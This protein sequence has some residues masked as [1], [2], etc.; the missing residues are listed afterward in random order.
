MIENLI[1]VGKMADLNKYKESLNKFLDLVYLIQKDISGVRLRSTLVLQRREFSEQIDQVI[2]SLNRDVELVEKGMKNLKRWLLLRKNAL[3]AI[4]NLYLSIDKTI[5]DSRN[6]KEVKDRIRMFGKSAQQ[7][8]V[9]SLLYLEDLWNKDVEGTMNSMQKVA[10]IM[11][12]THEKIERYKQEY[13]LDAD[14]LTSHI[15]SMFNYLLDEEF[16]KFEKLNQ[17]IRDSILPDI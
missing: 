6:E 13:N 3:K 12:V 1:R 17:K 2:E 4:E 14:E 7:E 16:E 5:N 10:S 15:D 11:K 8:F 9:L